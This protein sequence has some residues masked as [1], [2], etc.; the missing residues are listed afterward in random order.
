ML[1]KILTWGGIAFLIFFVAFRPDSAAN[2]VK[3]LG[4]TVMDIA[5]GFGDFFGSLVA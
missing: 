1:K 2:V 3:T 4:G 5:Q